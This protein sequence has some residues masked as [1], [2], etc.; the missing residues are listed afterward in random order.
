MALSLVPARPDPPPPRAD[1][2]SLRQPIPHLRVQDL[3]DPVAL[4]I[5]TSLV[6]PNGCGKNNACTLRGTEMKGVIFATPAWAR[7]VPG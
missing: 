6:G 3:A 2:A 7:P 4:D 5:L 1:A